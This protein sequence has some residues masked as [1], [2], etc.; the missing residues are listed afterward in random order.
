MQLLMRTE[1]LLLLA[2]GTYQTNSVWL[3][4]AV[5]PGSDRDA[6]KACFCSGATRHSTYD[7]RG[8]V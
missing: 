8:V 2:V 3:Q 5:V 6:V 7:D 1:V 4:C